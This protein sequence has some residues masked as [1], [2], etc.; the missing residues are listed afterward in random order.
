MTGLS[1]H[2]MIVEKG[3]STK[4]WNNNYRHAMKVGHPS[5]GHYALKA[6]RSKHLNCMMNEKL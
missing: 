5:F 6:K 4:C 2:L 3:A 1:D